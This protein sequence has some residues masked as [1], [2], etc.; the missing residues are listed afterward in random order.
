MENLCVTSTRT[1]PYTLEDLG[2]KDGD[3]VTIRAIA[4]EIA[5]NDELAAIVAEE[6]RKNN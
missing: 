3:L 6:R 4:I 5:N 1:S 2:F